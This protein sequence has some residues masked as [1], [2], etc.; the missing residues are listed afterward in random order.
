MVFRRP[1]VRADLV[2]ARF[3]DLDAVFIGHAH[4]DHAMD[5]PAVAAA[6]PRARI[7]GDPVLVELGR[8]LGIPAAR[9][10]VVEPGERVTIGDTTV[11]A[12]AAAHGRLPLG[13]LLNTLTLRG[14]G[15]P[16]TPLRYPQGGVLAYRV[17]AGGRS[18]YIQGSAG[19]NP[20]GLEGQAPV[21]ALIACLALR[22]DTPNYLRLLGARLRPRVLIPCH[23][24]DLFRP[25]DAAP[26]GV[27]RLAW[28]DFLADARALEAEHGTRL[29]CPP[30]D[31]LASW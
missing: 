21:D 9:L 31:S 2:A 12:V 14:H 7:H 6:S 15:A 26:R 8:R 16:R 28:N 11:T 19:L 5:L 20:A 25:L 13:R 10:R 22:H 23:H 24:D 29:W 30:R 27:F 17:E 18:F 3:R 4:Y 1:R